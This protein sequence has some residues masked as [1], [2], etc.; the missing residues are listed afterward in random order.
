MKRYLEILVAPLCVLLLFIIVGLIWNGLNLPPQQELMITIKDYF[1]S[2]GIW[3]VFL[4]SILE[5][6]FVVGAYMP[7]SLVIFL[8]VILSIG[9]PIK[10]IL[11]VLSVI[12]GFLIGFS[13]DFILGRYGWYKLLAHFGFKKAIESTK[14]RIQKYG[15]SIPWIGYHNPDLGSLVATSYGILNYNYKKFLLITVPPVMAWCAF[16]GFIT[17]IFGNSI[18]NILGYKTLIIVL[19][20]WVA[21][22]IVEVRFV[23][24]GNF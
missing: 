10:A 5:A 23:N 7:G 24:K 11:V 12:V 18:F 8:G 1:N 17:Y 3:L 16:W 13:I 21:V 19:V 14:I 20:V 22:R 2:Y 4:A 15:Y 6:A 9:N